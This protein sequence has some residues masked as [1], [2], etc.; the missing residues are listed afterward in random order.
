[1]RFLDNVFERGA[2][3]KC[4]FWGPITSFDSAA[5]GNQWSGNT[6]TD[7]TAVPPAN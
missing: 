2:G 5:P 6:W 3:G 1:M 7:G 4:G